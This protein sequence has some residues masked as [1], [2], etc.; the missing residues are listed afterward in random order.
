MTL[1]RRQLALGLTGLP[2]LGA[3]APAL[4]NTKPLTFVFVE[5]DDCEPCKR[6]HS[7]EGHWWK[8]SAEYQRVNTVFVRARRLRNALDDKVWPV[9]LRRHRDAAPPK[10][11]PAYYVLRHEELVLSTAGYTAW[12]REVYPALREMVAVADAVRGLQAKS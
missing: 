10:G 2:M 9:H 8:S 3:A 6:W 11:I 4:A 7:N 5:A 1:S 12:R